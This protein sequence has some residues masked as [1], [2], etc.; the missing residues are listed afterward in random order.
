M[1]RYPAGNLLKVAVNENVAIQEHTAT[2]TLS[3]K[4]VAN[5]LINVKQAG[6]APVFTIDPALK[7]QQFGSDGES[8]LLKVDTNIPFTA[9]SDQS[10]CQVEILSR[11]DRNLRITVSENGT[12]TPV[13]QK[14]F[15]QPKVLKT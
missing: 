11:T 4:D 7:T 9:V 12:I 5:V 6:T 2:V 3:A 8:S 14:L 1:Y 10:W 15:F 13:R